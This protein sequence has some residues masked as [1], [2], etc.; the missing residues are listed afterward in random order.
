MAAL[1]ILSL[2]L[3]ARM[4]GRLSRGRPAFLSTLLQSYAFQICLAINSK[5]SGRPDAGVGPQVRRLPNVPPPPAHG[6]DD[7]DDDDDSDDD[8]AEFD[9]CTPVLRR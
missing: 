3:S 8:N 4:S 9:T 1:T 7:G 2:R 5:F 6:G